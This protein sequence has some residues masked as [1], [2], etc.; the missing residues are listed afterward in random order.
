MHRTGY[1]PRRK[2]YFQLEYMLIE[3]VCKESNYKLTNKQN[4]RNKTKPNKQINKQTNNTTQCIL[5]NYTICE[6]E[7]SF[8]IFVMLEMLHQCNK[9]CLVAIFKQKK[10]LQISF[11]KCKSVHVLLLWAKCYWKIP[12]AKCSFFKK[13]WS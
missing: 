11:Q 6:Y 9:T 4:K 1:C 5:T 7:I 2:S 12:L 3:F 10:C 13:N 8:Q